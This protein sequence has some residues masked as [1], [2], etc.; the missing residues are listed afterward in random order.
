MQI[1][2]YPEIFSFLSY[3]KKTKILDVIPYMN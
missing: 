3:K 1:F 2:I